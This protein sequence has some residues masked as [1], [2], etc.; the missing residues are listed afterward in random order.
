MGLWGELYHVPP[1]LQPQHLLRKFATLNLPLSPVQPIRSPKVLYQSLWSWDR[2]GETGIGNC[3]SSCTR[4]SRGG[5]SSQHDTPSPTV[6]GI[7]R[8]Y[9]CQVENWKEGPSTWC[10]TIW[11]HVHRV[12]FGVWLACPSHPLLNSLVVYQFG[13][14]VIVEKVY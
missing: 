3:L 5:Y 2:G 11:A 10:A 7:K 14:L 13:Q 1:C 6:G 8:E 9:K 4:C 12:H